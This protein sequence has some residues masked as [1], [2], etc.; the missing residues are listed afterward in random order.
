MQENQRRVALKDRRD[1][2]DELALFT[3][4]QSASILFISNSLPPPYWNLDAVGIACHCS[5]F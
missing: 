4:T 1:P 3:G 2:P 5:S